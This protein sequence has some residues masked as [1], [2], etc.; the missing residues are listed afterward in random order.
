VAR[1]VRG[2]INPSGALPGLSLIAEDDATAVGEKLF[3]SLGGDTA[4]ESNAAWAGTLMFS[5]LGD[6]QTGRLLRAGADEFAADSLDDW[7]NLLFARIAYEQAWW[8]S[9]R[10]SAWDALHEP[11]RFRA[12]LLT[13]AEAALVS[14]RSALHLDTLVAGQAA[15][16]AMHVV[17]GY[18]ESAT[19]GHLA[20]A[21]GG[22]AVKLQDGESLTAAAS[23]FF[24]PLGTAGQSIA[25]RF[26][27]PQEL[28][29]LAQGGGAL[30]GPARKALGGLSPYLVEGG[31]A[32]S[33][34]LASASQAYLHARME[35]LHARL[36]YDAR[37]L[38]YGLSSVSSPQVRGDAAFV[39][40]AS[41]ISVWV[42]NSLLLPSYRRV[43]FGTAASESFTG[44]AKD[45]YF[46]GGPGDDSLSGG[47]GSNILEGGSGFDTYVVGQ[48][49]DLVRDADGSGEVVFAGVT[50]NG[51]A[52]LSPSVW[53]SADQ[54]FKYV[55]VDSA[56]ETR[57]RVSDAQSAHT[58]EIVDFSPG[59]LGI[60]LTGDG[61]PFPTP[62]TVAPTDLAPG[63]RRDTY[64]SASPGADLFDTGPLYD[65]VLA[66]GGND[67]IFL[68]ADT[69][70]T[71]AGPGNDLVFGEADNDYLMGGPLV[72]D[73]AQA[74]ND[75]DVIAGGP[76]NDL[77]NG[78]I[79]DDVLY[80]E[81][82]DHDL[83]GADLNERGDWILGGAGED[84]IFGSVRNDFLHGGA[85]S[86]VVYAGGGRDV[87]LGDGGIDFHFLP[88]T[89]NFGPNQ[90]GAA[91]HTWSST[92][93][94]QTVTSVSQQVQ[95]YLQPS[96]YFQWTT[97]TSGPDFAFERT[98]MPTGGNYVRVV[99]QG[100][101]DIIDAGAGND[102]VA[103]QTGNDLIYGG[104]G[105]DVL[106]GD[107]FAPLP[108]PAD[109]G[110]D[111][112]H[113]GPGNDTIHGGAGNDLLFGDA[114]D[115]VIYGDEPGDP[116]G[117]D[118]LYGGSGNDE[119]YGR[120]GND[121]LHGDEGDDLLVGGEGDDTLYGGDGNDIVFGDGPE[122]GT[123]AD[124]L[125]GGDGDDVLHGDDGEDVLYGDAGDDTLYGG[126]GNDVLVGGTGVDLLDG[127]AGDDVYVFSIGD[128]PSSLGASETIV[129]SAG[130]NRIRFDA[131][132]FAGSV[133]LTSDGANLR[134]QFTGTDVV[135]VTGGAGGSVVQT[136][137]FADGRV[138]T[139][140]ELAGGSLVKSVASPGDDRLHGTEIADSIDGGAGN[141]LIFG[142]G[143][144]DILLGGDGHDL[145]DGM[146]GDDQIFGGTGD[147]RLFGSRGDDQIIGGDGDDMLAGG[148]GSDI[149]DGGD[150]NDQ[151]YGGE[152][153][154][155]LYGGPGDDLLVGGPGS[156]HL[157]G[158]D[159]FDTYHFE[160][161]DAVPTDGQPT[162][163]HDSGASRLRFG[164][165]I[166]AKELEVGIMRHRNTIT[167]GFGDGVVHIPEAHGL[168]ELEFQFSDGRIY[169][170]DE[171][172][173]LRSGKLGVAT[174]LATSYSDV[175]LVDAP[176][177]S[178][179]CAAAPAL[180]IAAA[181]RV[182]CR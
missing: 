88:T 16:P 39:D 34:E 161:G 76:G 68:G 7:R 50:L 24:S 121:E 78:G 10:E 142:F 96:H 36:G 137:E 1:R 168:Q 134:V 149:L 127:G 23:Q 42:R 172:F 4:Y 38:E 27:P 44:T 11:P 55:L 57:L 100:G 176:P 128:A 116:A 20:G 8:A 26:A 35:M 80:A 81:D 140:A 148:A 30:A 64:E 53:T 143:G 51:G 41:G 31:D 117:D 21:F 89:L 141:D 90:A 74:D 33:P 182:I 163:I 17:N 162:Y 32:P 112:I 94:W 59:D 154:D 124:T 144:D 129:D 111:E 169:T 66:G 37:R 84:L 65:Y 179:D 67:I 165:G 97:D 106:W 135:V 99:A 180:L 152:G 2:T 119:L 174:T 72:G 109:Y 160:V 131:G 108:S 58:V 83:N 70:R 86:D 54:R 147:D 151:L 62:D 159:G 95:A 47:A 82:T 114:G 28:R 85:G 13:A 110:D 175:P 6:D 103:G 91:R 125:F 132:I 22:E 46:H 164:P 158:G 29:E 136:Y 133:S 52:R 87:I 75:R 101:A 25:A 122:G 61:D 177:A 157:E 156:N 98:P 3:V 120:A 60:A 104:S 113:G 138:F 63:G 79:G 145:I 49:R 166:T 5:G 9:V 150:G 126:S 102:W 107:D 56:G 69:D 93:G 18:G 123:G 15:G 40:H 130:A 171:M 45:D 92:Q 77:I 146:D 48:G 153:D 173:S 14:G 105:D 139:H 12:D 178:V 118:M 181:A 43:E 167:V 155:A 71:L 73:A 19:F 170:Q 115:D